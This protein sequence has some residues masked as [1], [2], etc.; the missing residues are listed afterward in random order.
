R[1]RKDLYFAAGGLHP[2]PYRGAGPGGDLSLCFK[3]AGES[4]SLRGPPRRLEDS[5]PGLG[6][7][8]YMAAGMGLLLS[9][10][11][12]FRSRITG[13]AE[14]LGLNVATVRTAEEL[15]QHAAAQRPICVILDLHNPGLEIATVVARLKANE[16][17]P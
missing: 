14:A 7:T 4:S 3:P 10:D 15:L 11:L 9:D 12:L 1:R 2:H 16:P 5:P 6:D 8:E 17:P 13:T